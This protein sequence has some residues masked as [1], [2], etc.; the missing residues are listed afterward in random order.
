M[1]NLG[2]EGQLQIASFHPC[3][4]SAGTQPEDIE[5]CTTRSHPPTLHLLREASVERA[6]ASVPDPDEIYRRNI[7]TMRRLGR[8]GWRKLWI[9]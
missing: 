2:R 4:L 1:P 6:L 5:N 9:D 3:D 8:E 7:L